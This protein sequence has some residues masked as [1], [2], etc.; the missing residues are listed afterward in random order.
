MDLKGVLE[1]R[2]K[3]LFNAIEFND[4]TKASKG[5]DNLMNNGLLTQITH[6]KII[7]LCP[8]LII[9]KDEIDK[10]LDIISK[11]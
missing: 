5:L 7:R 11:S 10:S 3:G 6:N 1:I 8:P 2:G 4:S 9:N